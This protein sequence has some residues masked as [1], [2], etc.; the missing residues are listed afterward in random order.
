MLAKLLLALF[1]VAASHASPLSSNHDV[2]CE[3]GLFCDKGQTCMSK[4][5]GAGAMLACSPHPNA[6]IC[7]DKRF[8]CRAGSTC[9]NQRCTWT[10][11][12]GRTGS[13]QASTSE[14]ARFVESGDGVYI[15][16]TDAPG[17]RNIGSDVCNLL[18][19]RLPS[20]CICEAFLDGLGSSVKC[21]TNIG[22]VFNSFIIAHFKPCDAT[23]TIGYSFGAGF[24]GTNYATSN[25]SFTGAYDR[26]Y[27]ISDAAFDM[28]YN[29]I[30]PQ[31]DVSGNVSTIKNARIRADVSLDFCG[32]VNTITEKYSGCAGQSRE[33][34]RKF[35]DYLEVTGAR[36]PFLI[37]LQYMPPCMCILILL[38]LLM[39]PCSDPFPQHQFPYLSSPA[40][41]TFVVF[42]P[43]NKLPNF[44]RL[45]RASRGAKRGVYKCQDISALVKSP[46]SWS[47]T[48]CWH[49]VAAAPHTT[50]AH[51]THAALS[52][53]LMPQ[54]CAPP[55]RVAF[56]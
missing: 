30:Y 42:A 24:L 7:N 1:V 50:E 41:S 55:T 8:S 14:N 48:S 28:I 33:M 39:L 5:P 10:P 35:S 26:Q 17:L 16:P 23:P 47:C 4:A 46:C 43:P 21:Q 44:L 6:V 13:F 12:S 9:Y 20:F 18:I 52:A 40:I 29:G 32:N 37:E 53:A 36:P 31:A 51:S 27:R 2:S 54:S 34:G 22:D 11:D 49:S 3:N 19:P 25:M 56:S 15:L 38:N 45:V